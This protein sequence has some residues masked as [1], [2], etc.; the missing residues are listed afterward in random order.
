MLIE[1][2][3]DGSCLVLLAFTEQ[4]M[5]NNAILTYTAIDKLMQRYNN[6]E[7]RRS[8]FY[9]EY[10]HPHLDRRDYYTDELDG[11]GKVLNDR[12]FQ[13]NMDRVCGM[14]DDLHVEKRPNLR[15]ILTGVWSPYGPYASEAAKLIHE[16]GQIKLGPRSLCDLVSNGKGGMTGT[17]AKL[18][19]WDF[20]NPYD[21][22]ITSMAKLDTHI[23]HPVRYW[24]DDSAPPVPLPEKQLELG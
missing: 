7:C 22:S 13:F 3:D 14:I 1:K 2:Y 11:E 19:G 21:Q 24:I 23:C 9:T 18:I 8:P 5:N 4:I 20:M 10:G 12:L 15:H 17:V 16:T 6:E